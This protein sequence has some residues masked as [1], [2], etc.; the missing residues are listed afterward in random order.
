MTCQTGQVF[1]I[2]EADCVIPYAS[3]NCEY[4]CKT[5]VP[6]TASWTHDAITTTE[7]GN[8]VIIKNA[9]KFESH[10]NGHTYD[11]RAA[12]RGGFTG[13]NPINFGKKF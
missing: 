8:T 1:E 7:S 12:F 3:F 2:D 4:R 10:R 9:F 13:S 5:P 6:T 11:T